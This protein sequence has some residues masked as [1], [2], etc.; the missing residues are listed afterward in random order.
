VEDLFED[1]DLLAFM[2]GPSEPAFFECEY[3]GR[4]GLLARGF[5]GEKVQAPPGFRWVNGDHFLLVRSCAK[6]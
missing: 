1:P 3:G 5:A 2:E 6:D 4:S